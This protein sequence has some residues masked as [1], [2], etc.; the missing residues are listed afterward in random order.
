MV[1]LITIK[2]TKSAGS[3]LIIRGVLAIIFAVLVLLWPQ[4]SVATLVILFAIFLVLD[5]ITE[6]TQWFT[7]RTAPHPGPGVTRSG[8]WWPASSRLPAGF[9]PWF[10][11]TSPH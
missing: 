5:G 10:G 6:I 8:C 4:L 7:H 2:P 3:A 9:S 11:P 1:E